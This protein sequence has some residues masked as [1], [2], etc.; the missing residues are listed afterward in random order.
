MNF[1]F[2]RV[3]FTLMSEADHLKNI[4][5]IFISCLINCSCPLPIFFIGSF[6]FSY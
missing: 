3:R 5:A 4:C 6:D 2:I 1:K